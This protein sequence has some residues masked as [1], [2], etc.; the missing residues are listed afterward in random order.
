MKVRATEAYELER[1]QELEVQS[2]AV[3]PEAVQEAISEEDQQ[4][5]AAEVISFNAELPFNLLTEEARAKVEA[6]LSR[7]AVAASAAIADEV[8]GQSENAEQ[9]AKTLLKE[10]EYPAA[11][12]VLTECITRTPH[13]AN[14]H[15]L[16]GTVY[17]KLGEVELGATEYRKFLQYAPPDHADYGRVREILSAYYSQDR[18]LSQ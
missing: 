4:E 17:A 11:K 6:E 5:L 9:A 18:D 2:I 8:L 15:K 13:N 12:R 16:L 14:C 1:E 7:E 10:K 3:E